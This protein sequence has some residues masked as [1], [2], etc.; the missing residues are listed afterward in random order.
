MEHNP[1]L[2]L[3]TLLPV[4]CGVVLITF[5][6]YQFITV[7][8]VIEWKTAS[9]MDTVGFY[10]FRSLDSEGPFEKIT[11][12]PIPSSADPLVGGSYQFSDTNTNA[13]QRYYYQLIEIE[14]SGKENIL[15][16]TSVIPEHNGFLMGIA[17]VVLIIFGVLLARFPGQK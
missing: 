13:G 16:E 5:A 10:I 3:R 1:Y 11:T 4:I 9:E 14:T 6:A 12:Y 2:K 15:G 17:G 7:E 8:V